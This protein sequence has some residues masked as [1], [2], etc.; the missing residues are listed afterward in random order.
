MVRKKRRYREKNGRCNIAIITNK[1]GRIHDFFK[2]WGNLCE[3]G[4]ILWDDWRPPTKKQT[5][6][7]IRKYDGRIPKILI[8]MI[9]DTFP[10]LTASEIVSVQPLTA[11]I[12]EDH[13]SGES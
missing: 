3:D 12:D 11:P 7:S 13:N 5:K 10:I 9:R 2:G 8:P 6:A 4:S 1:N